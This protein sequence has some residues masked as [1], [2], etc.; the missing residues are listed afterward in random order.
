MEPIAIR[1]SGVMEADV[2]VAVAENLNPRCA[3]SGIVLKEN[4]PTSATVRSPVGDEGGIAR[5]RSV[6]EVREA[7]AAPAD[8]G[9]IVDKC[10]ITGGRGV[11]ELCEAAT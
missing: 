4:C 7:A 5:G 3:T 8:R 1:R 2:Q 9:A 11:V 6:V 10:P